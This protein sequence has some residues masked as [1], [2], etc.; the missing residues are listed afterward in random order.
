MRML[1]LVAAVLLL[2]GCDK[3]RRYNRPFE[4]AV[5]N[6]CMEATRATGFWAQDLAPE[7]CR[8]VAQ[9]DFEAKGVVAELEKLKAEK[10]AGG[11]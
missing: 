1:M 8:K 7:R 9:A 2:G 5:Y 11:W 3:Q 6:D 10:A 4:A